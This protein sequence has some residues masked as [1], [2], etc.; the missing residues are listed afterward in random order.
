MVDYLNL[1]DSFRSLQTSS[2]ISF[3]ISLCLIL[4]M[5]KDFLSQSLY[6][7]CKQR[8]EFFA[9]GTYEAVILSVVK[10][11]SLGKQGSCYA[12]PYATR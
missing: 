10:Y 5:C 11:V 2:I 6:R 4:Q 3:V 12:L 8:P 7:A 9:R 1:L